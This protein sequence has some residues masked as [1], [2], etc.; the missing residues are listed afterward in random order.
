MSELRLKPNKDALEALIAEAES[1]SMENA[2][3][4]TTAVLRSALA[5][6]IEVY[7]NEQATEDEVAAAEKELKTAIDQMLASTGGSTEN[8]SQPDGN[9]DGGQKGTGNGGSE[10]AGEGQNGGANGGQANGSGS[11]AVKTGDSTNLL[12]WAVLL[13]AAGAAGGTAVRVSRRRK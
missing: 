7:D 10:D 6:A 9:T 4:E 3:E 13:A 1:L 12:L 2:D 5:K 11:R 8:P